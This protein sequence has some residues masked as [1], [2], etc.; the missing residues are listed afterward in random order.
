MHDYFV[1]QMETTRTEVVKY[2]M[3]WK[4]IAWFPKGLIEPFEY[5]YDTIE[6]Y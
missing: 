6:D 4:I 1:Q 3:W 5:I 2:L